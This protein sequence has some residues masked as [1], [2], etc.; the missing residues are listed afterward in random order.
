MKTRTISLYLIGIFLSGT[1]VSI[2]LIPMAIHGL[3]LE[4]IAK[5]AFFSV[6]AL[7]LGNGLVRRLN[8]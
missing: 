5:I 4:G 2:F 7:W 1:G 3:T 8:K 6:Y